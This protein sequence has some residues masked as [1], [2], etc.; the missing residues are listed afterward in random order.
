MTP[1]LRHAPYIVI[2][3][4]GARHEL[5]IH[6]GQRRGAKCLLMN[7]VARPA[8]IINVCYMFGAR[9][10]AF[11]PAPAASSGVSGVV[12]PALW[13][14]DGWWV[15]ESDGVCGRSQTATRPQII[16]C[17][18]LFSHGALSDGNLHFIRR[19]SWMGDLKNLLFEN[20]NAST[21]FESKVC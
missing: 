20:C 6:R 12:L 14:V 1:L 2:V 17:V 5:F 21:I 13:R 15:R 4:V 11:W 18:P 16:S 3:V 9:A 7:L 8:A 10:A 19:L